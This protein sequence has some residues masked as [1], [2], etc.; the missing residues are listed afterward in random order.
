MISAVLPLLLIKAKYQ[1]S[2]LTSPVPDEV[3]IADD[4]STEETK[5]LIDRYAEKMPVPVIWVG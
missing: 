1:I 4:G 5:K 2:Y 3:V